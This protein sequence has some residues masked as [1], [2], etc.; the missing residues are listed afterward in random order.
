[1]SKEAISYM[2]AAG[3]DQAIMTTAAENNEDV[4]KVIKIATARD[5]VE[6]RQRG[7]ILAQEMGATSTQATLVAT[8][9]SE[10]ARNIILYA[11]SGTITMTRKDK[12][13]VSGIQITALDKGPGITNISKALMNG[14]STSGGLGLGL[15]GVKQIADAFKISSE[16]GEGVRVEVVMWLVSRSK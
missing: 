11:S 13:L 12:D 8:V 6:A 16:P 5:I 3:V 14:Y 1:M 15:P 7:R 9:I 10:L 2:P 4:G